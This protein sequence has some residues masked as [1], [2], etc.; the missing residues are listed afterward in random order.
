MHLSSTVVNAML[1]SVAIAFAAGCSGES[2]FPASIPPGPSTPTRPSTLMDLARSGL[3]PRAL[4]LLR[5]GQPVPHAVK[6]KRG[7]LRDLYVSDFGADVVVL[8]NTSYKNV[9]TISKGLLSPD[10]DFVDAA[11]NLY[12]ADYD[13]VH[14][15]EYKP[16]AKSPSYTYRAGMTD[17]VNVS[18]DSHGNVYEA[19][20]DGYYVNEYAQKSDTVVNSCPLSGGAEGIAID[21]NNDVFVDYNLT[22]SGTGAIVEYKGGLAGCNQALLKPRLKFAGGMVLDSHGRLIICDA[23]APAVDV[24]APPYSAI[25]GH[26]GSSYLFPFHVTLSRNNKLA[27]VADVYNVLVWDYSSGSLVTTLDDANG[28]TYPAGAVDSENAVY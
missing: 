14:I 9:G 23:Y 25:T 21:S 10:G 19:D 28:L 15:Q 13:G 3:S 18:V 5:S 2:P 27:F 20:Y 12:V 8:K 6:A 16:G 22:S 1:A 11:G 7:G 26:L 24:I 17:P 4:A